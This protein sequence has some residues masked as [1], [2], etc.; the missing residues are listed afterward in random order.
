MK[1]LTAAERQR[2]RRKALRWAAKFSA[3]KPHDRAAVREAILALVEPKQYELA[4]G[5]TESS[6]EPPSPAGRDVK[7]GGRSEA[8]QARRA[9]NAKVSEDDTDASGGRPGPHQGPR[10]GQRNTAGHSGLVPL[11][12][13]DLEDGT[14]EVG[15]SGLTLI[16]PRQKSA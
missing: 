10:K 9:T 13:F 2:I 16:N 1:R 15:R 12:L 3:L 4:L 7:A 14:T 11:R 6:T 5:L 8:T